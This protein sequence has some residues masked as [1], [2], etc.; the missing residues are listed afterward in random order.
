MDRSRFIASIVEVSRR[1]EEFHSDQNPRSN[2][3]HNVCAEGGRETNQKE[4]N[5]A[6]V[7]YN[8]R[9]L[10]FRVYA[11]VRGDCNG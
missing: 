9:V 1:R 5:L 4:R 6:Y 7:Y 8:V 11:T 2:M 3:N 10:S